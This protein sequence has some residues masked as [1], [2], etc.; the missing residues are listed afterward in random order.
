FHHIAS[1]GFSSTPDNSDNSSNR[2][3]TDNS[4]NRSFADLSPRQA[5]TCAVFEAEISLPTLPSPGDRVKWWFAIAPDDL[6]G[7]ETLKL[8]SSMQV[9]ICVRFLDSAH[10]N[11][12]APSLSIRSHRLDTIRVIGGG[13]L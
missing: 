1:V 10:P 6:G 13:P 12:I 7:Y 11:P 2:G 8:I 4:D 5:S 9:G 3:N